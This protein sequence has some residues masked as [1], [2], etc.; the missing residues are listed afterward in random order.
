MKLKICSYIQQQP[1][2]IGY[3][4]WQ[5]HVI[6]SFVYSKL[7]WKAVIVLIQINNVDSIQAIDRL[8]CLNEM[9]MVLLHS[10]YQQCNDGPTKPLHN[11]P[12]NVST[13]TLSRSS[14]GSRRL[15]FDISLLSRCNMII[16]IS[17]RWAQI[18][19]SRST[20]LVGV[21]R[22]GWCFIWR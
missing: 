18:Q 22:A 8:F 20:S 7:L 1:N 12:S 3:V 6:F 19:G 10:I 4:T 13:T 15:H 14:R 17:R 2:C 5:S 11:W 16:I 9:L 21:D